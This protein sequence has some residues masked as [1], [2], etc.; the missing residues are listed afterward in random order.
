MHPITRPP[1][2]RPPV[3]EITRHCA[4]LS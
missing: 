4:P 3:G 1:A 2:P